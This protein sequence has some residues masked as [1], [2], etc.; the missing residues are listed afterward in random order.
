M[1]RQ[2]K[3]SHLICGLFLMLMVLFTGTA[4]AGITINA[5]NFG[6]QCGQQDSTE[7]HAP[8]GGG[9]TLPSGPHML[10]LWGS[11]V[12]WSH[13]NT[14]N[15]QYKFDVLD[16]Y[17][18]AIAADSSITGVIYTFGYTPCWAEV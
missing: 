2:S 4:V 9:I 3:N 11:S 12:D 13:L 7:T 17:L 16:E 1:I 15:G 10:R 5:K 8:S 18:D 14:A 6:M